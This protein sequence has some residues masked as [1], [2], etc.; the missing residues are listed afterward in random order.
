MR[1]AST[2]SQLRR[3]GRWRAYP[4]PAISISLKKDGK[5]QLALNSEKMYWIVEKMDNLFNKSDSS[6]IWTSITDW[7]E[8][9]TGI[10]YDHTLLSSRPIMTPLSTERAMLTSVYF[11]SRSMTKHR[12][13]TSHLTGADS[14]VFR[15]RSKEPLSGKGK[16]ADFASCYQKN[17]PE[18]EKRWTNL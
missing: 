6:Y 7:N 17:A 15:S 12:R 11:P 8:T 5:Y 4:R 10:I 1:T 3:H 2:A 14:C 9:R 18:V 13:S 16:S